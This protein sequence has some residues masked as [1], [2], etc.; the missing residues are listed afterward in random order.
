MKIVSTVT[1]IA[2][3]S[4]SA[5]TF[6]QSGDMGSMKMDGKTTQDCADMK[7]MSSM[8]GMDMQGMDASKCKDKMKDNTSEDAAKA[9]GP[10]SY[11]TAGVVKKVDMTHGRVTLAHG[12][13]KDLGWPAMTMTFG[14]K[15]KTLLDKVAVGSKVHVEFKKEGEDYFVTSVK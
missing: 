15:D 5:V 8:K 7:G 2:A 10:E 1:L 9:K 4:F 11:E 3:L 13:V 6:A 12:A 14:V